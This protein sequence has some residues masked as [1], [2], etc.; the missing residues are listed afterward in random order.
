MKCKIRLL[1][2][3]FTLC[4]FWGS[5][6]F[7]VISSESQE[8]PIDILTENVSLNNHIIDLEETKILYCEISTPINAAPIFRNLSKNK[9]SN[10]S[11]TKYAFSFIKKYN[12]LQPPSN[13]FKSIYRFPSKTTEGRYRLI[14][15]GILII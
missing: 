14:C 2:I 10:V 13:L 11:S 15:F 3:C 9:R 6:V 7:S 8:R 12:I 4:F 1:F 5:I